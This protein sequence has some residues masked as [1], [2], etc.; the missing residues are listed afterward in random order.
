MKPGKKSFLFVVLLA[1]V[2]ASCQDQS[3]IVDT[4]VE[5][6]KHNWSYTEKVKIPLN[7]ES[8]DIPCNLYLNLR[9]TS[10]YKYSNI[11]LLIHITGPD[12]K[13]STE[14]REFKLALPDGEWL[15]SGSGNLYSYQILFKENF[16]FPLKGK[17]IIELEQNMRDN[18]LDHI[19]DAGIRVERVDK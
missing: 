3:A 8:E 11:F 2:L 16:K 4:N 14:R 19:T 18:P 7:I 10:D 6:D 12:G 13:K 5:L 9:H 15:G 1:M 17:Y